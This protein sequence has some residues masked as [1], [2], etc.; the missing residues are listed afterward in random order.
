MTLPLS[1][2]ALEQARATK[3]A[4]LDPRTPAHASTASMDVDSPHMALP[5]V[6]TSAAAS[7]TAVAATPDAAAPRRQVN[8]GDTVGDEFDDA[9]HEDDRFFVNYTPPVELEVAAPDSTTPI[10]AIGGVAADGAGTPSAEAAAAPAAAAAAAAAVCA[11]AVA[12][13][14]I[15]ATKPATTDDLAA[16]IAA[17]LKK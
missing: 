13:T 16:L 15:V 12:A 7:P 2:A 17:E 1:A 8:I 5:A 11:P 9:L 4:R 6:R 3:A 14:P 10:V